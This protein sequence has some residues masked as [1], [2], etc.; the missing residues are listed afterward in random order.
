MTGD[1]LGSLREY[2]RLAPWN[3]RDLA[4]TAAAILERAGARPLNPAANT[5]PNQRTIRFYV[6]RGLVTPP[7][8]RGTAATYGYR[9]LLQVLGIKLRQMEGA[10][11]EQIGRE[12]SE[13]TGDLLERRVASVLGPELPTPE[14]LAWPGPSRGRA[15]QAASQASPRATGSVEGSYLWHR[16]SL[17]P[18][19]ELHLAAGHPVLHH[20]ERLRAMLDALADTL[21]T[22]SGGN[23]RR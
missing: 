20:P 21:R 16:W 6:A 9:H 7:D 12:L 5:L 23:H 19:A 3:A 11:L 2:R 10:R 22:D 15:G 18:G 17:G 8:G 14:E 4:R 1:S 13:M